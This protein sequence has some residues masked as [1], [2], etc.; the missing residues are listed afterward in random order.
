MEI[1]EIW[2]DVVG[3]EEICQVSNIGNITTKS[4]V[5]INGRIY[6]PRVLTKRTDRH[7]YHV[8]RICTNGKQHSK[9]VHRLVAMSFCSGDGDFVNH[10]NGIKTDNRAE[11]LE[12]CTA[13]ENEI[14]AYRTGLKKPSKN[15]RPGVEHSRFGGFIEAI[16]ILSGDSFILAGRRNIEEMGFQQSSVIRCAKNIQK[17]HRGHC[18]RYLEDAHERNAGTGN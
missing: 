5:A 1:K 9:L 10:I 6:D 18:F 13:S 11:N 8:V 7:G 17:S 4:R 3:F 15:T 16:S 12:W 14:H 2:R